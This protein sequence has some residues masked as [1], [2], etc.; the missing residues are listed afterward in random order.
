MRFGFLVGALIAFLLGISRPALADQPPPSCYQQ[1]NQQHNVE[2]SDHA[3]AGQHKGISSRLW[4][5]T[6]DSDCVRVTSLNGFKANGRFVEWGWGLGYDCKGVYRTGTTA[7]MAWDTPTIA[8]HCN[9][10]PAADVHAETF[11]TFIVQDANQNTVWSVYLGS[12]DQ[13]DLQDTADVDFSASDIVTNGERD[14]DG[15]VAWAHFTEL[16]GLTAG[17]DCCYSNFGDLRLFTDTDPGYKC[18]K[19]TNTEHYVKPNDASG[20]ICPNA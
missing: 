15:D 1:P 9:T 18:F 12:T 17:P 11:R 10:F 7:F 8:P 13:A 16:Q 4:V 5:G 3:A 19:V 6:W 2:A 14:S 20:S